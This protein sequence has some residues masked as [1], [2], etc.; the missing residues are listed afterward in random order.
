MVENNAH[1]GRTWCANA[2]SWLTRW[3]KDVFVYTDKMRDNKDFR[4]S[5]HDNP[6]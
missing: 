5:G 6:I 3:T 4:S 1:I 2:W